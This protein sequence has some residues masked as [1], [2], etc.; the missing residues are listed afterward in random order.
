MTLE[1][2]HF[3]G[4]VII[5]TAMNPYLIFFPLVWSLEY[6]LNGERKTGKH[7]NHQNGAKVIL[8][9]LNTDLPPW[10]NKRPSARCTQV[11]PLTCY[12]CKSW[13]DPY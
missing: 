2:C 12:S 4:G 6:N 11:E 8:K 3:V 10:K 7:M 9:I 1:K 5:H 13:R